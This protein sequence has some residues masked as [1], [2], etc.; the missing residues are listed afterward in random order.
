[1][2]VVIQWFF[3]FFLVL[4]EVALA[5]RSRSNKINTISICIFQIIVFFFCL[6]VCLF[7]LDKDGQSKLIQF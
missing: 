3:F 7:V 5:Q 4:R 2:I 1:M 6:F